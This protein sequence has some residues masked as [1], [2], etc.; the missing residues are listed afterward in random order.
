[1]KKP[2][3]ADKLRPGDVVVTTPAYAALF[4]P[5]AFAHEAT[6]IR[7]NDITWTLRMHLPLA[8]PWRVAPKF[9]EKWTEEKHMGQFTNETAKLS[10]LTWTKTT[11]NNWV[12]DKIAAR[13]SFLD[14]KHYSVYRDG[15]YLGS[16]RS[17]EDAAERAKLN[18]RSDRNIMLEKWERDNPNEMPPGLTPVEQDE[19][20]RRHPAAGEGRKRGAD[21]V[22][23]KVRAEVG[24]KRVAKR[25]VG[26]GK[27]SERNAAILA[28]LARGCTRDEV[29]RV[30]GWQAV[31]MQQM[32]QSL[33]VGLRVDKSSKPFKYYAETVEAK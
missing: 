32:A 11:K 28:L 22:R 33:G 16:E 25:A 7:E 26:S 2:K 19:W 1:M 29:L 20:V 17:L 30:T 5:P 24:A 14:D 10:G 6:L 15:K 9:F 13:I 27:S 23:A 18:R 4:P 31:S 8:R 3:K 12:A 21:A